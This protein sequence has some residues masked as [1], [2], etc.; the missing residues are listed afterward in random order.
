[1]EQKVADLKDDD[2]LR[3]V[4]TK[5]GENSYTLVH[6]INGA[7]EHRA[8][9]VDNEE[10]SGFLKS[11]ALSLLRGNPENLERFEILFK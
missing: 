2:E 3:V 10:F 8:S 9:G 6:Y 7:E 5:D 1:M 11:V 4:A